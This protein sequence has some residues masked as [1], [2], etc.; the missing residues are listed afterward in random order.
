M[1]ATATSEKN[2]RN[3]ASAI[4]YEDLEDENFN[5]WDAAASNEEGGMIMVEEDFK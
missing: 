3:S 4:R 5:E 1:S 2:Y